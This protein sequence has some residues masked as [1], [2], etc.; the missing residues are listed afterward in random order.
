MQTIPTMIGVLPVAEFAPIS[1]SPPQQ[2]PGT[3]MTPKRRAQIATARGFPS[4]PEMWPH[5]AQAGFPGTIGFPHMG[6]RMLLGIRPSAEVEQNG[7]SPGRPAPHLG[8]RTIPGL[9]LTGT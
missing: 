1:I 8:H 5:L 2:P 9:A 6:H 3:P 4:T 7:I